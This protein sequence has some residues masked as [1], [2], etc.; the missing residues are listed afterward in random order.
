MCDFD[1]DTG[2]KVLRMFFRALWFVC[3]DLLWLGVFYYIGAIPV[4]MVSLGKLPSR[5][6]SELPEEDRRWYALIGVLV[7]I[8]LGFYYISLSSG[9][10][11]LG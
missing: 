2:T 6:P 4:W 7:T 5:W 9:A 3:F 11:A 10:A 1:G 8:G